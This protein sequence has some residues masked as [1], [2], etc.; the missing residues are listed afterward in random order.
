MQRFQGHVSNRDSIPFGRAQSTV[1]L[2]FCPPGCCPGPMFYFWVKK[3]ISYRWINSSPYPK[4]LQLPYFCHEWS[5]AGKLTPL[6]PPC[7]LTPENQPTYDLERLWAEALELHRSGIQSYLC[8]LPAKCC[9]VLLVESHRVDVRINKYK[10]LDT[11]P[12]I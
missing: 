4:L 5:H 12:S 11:C 2:T 1:W 8:C 9:W 3:D 6:I 7:L 10:M